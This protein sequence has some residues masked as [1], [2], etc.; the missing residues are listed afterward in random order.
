MRLIVLATAITCFSGCTGGNSAPATH[1]MPREKVVESTIE[2]SS[3]EPVGTDSVAAT[4]RIANVAATRTAIAG[5][6]FLVTGSYET[7]GEGLPPSGV[8]VKIVKI[9]PD[10]KRVIADEATA[11]ET[12]SGDGK[13]GFEAEVTAPKRPGKYAIAIHAGEGAEY[14]EPLAVVAQ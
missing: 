6:P 1:N 13:Y 14:E 10:G 11:K 8:T 12:Q 3:A 5:E 4:G 7:S 9:F 2:I